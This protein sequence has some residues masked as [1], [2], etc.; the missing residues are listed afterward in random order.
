MGTGLRVFLID[1]N[2]N[3][4]RL[5]AT[6]LNRLLRFEPH[7]RFPHYAGK[8]IRCAMVLLEVDGRRPLGIRH[9]DYFFIPF[10][11]KGRVNKKEWEKGIRLAMELMPPFPNEHHP[12]GVI[13][14][15][16]RFAKRRHDHQ[17]KWKPSRKVEDA[18]MDEI[19]G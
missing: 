13:D 7:E 10:D 19:F 15:Q 3:L 4:Q 2:N 16:H 1:E 12:K 18:I 11:S 14:A 17:V 8:Q 6:R 9:I 5:P